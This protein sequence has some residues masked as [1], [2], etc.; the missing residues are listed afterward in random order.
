MDILV[1]KLSVTVQEL[2][3]Q[4]LNIGIHYLEKKITLKEYKEFYNYHVDDC[5]QIKKFNYLKLVF[6][7]YRGYNILKKKTNL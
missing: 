1:N 7:T 2:N 6:H 5:G 3:N 4:F